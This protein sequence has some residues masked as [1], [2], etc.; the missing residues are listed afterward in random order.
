MQIQIFAPHWGSNELAP[1]VFIERVLAARFDGIEMSLPLEPALR[2]RWTGMIAQAGLGLIAQQWETALHP[3][4]EAHREALAAYLESACAARPLFVNSHTGKDYYTAQQNHALIALAGD[5]G[6]RHGV[7]IVHEI[8]RSRFSGHPALLLPVL[9]ELPELELTADLSHWCCACESLLEDQEATL[10]ATLPHV[11]HIHARV[12][13]PQG[14]QVADFRAPE[15]QA[16]LAAHL[17]WWDR[18]VALRRQA[19]AQ[20]ITLTPEFGPAPYTQ[21]LPYTGQPVSNA[22][23]LNV[24]MGAL[25]RQRYCA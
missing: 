10:A 22:W 16:A 2:Q 23:E 6:R 4:Y 11:R 20:R 9:R 12:G 5:I 19:G 1:E 7:P 8:H 18:I 13:H 14:P 3:Q 24:A 15:A 17:G 21:S 25:L